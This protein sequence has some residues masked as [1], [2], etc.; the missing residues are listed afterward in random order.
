MMLS[1]RCWGEDGMDTMMYC[2]SKVGKLLNGQGLDE[3]N[4]VVGI[5]IPVV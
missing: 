3:P 4:E 1:D 2:A 5:D